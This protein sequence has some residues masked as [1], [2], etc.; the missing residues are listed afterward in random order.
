MDDEEQSRQQR[1]PE[2]SSVVLAAAESRSELP[3]HADAGD[4]HSPLPIYA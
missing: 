3:G 4:D 2:T 1:P